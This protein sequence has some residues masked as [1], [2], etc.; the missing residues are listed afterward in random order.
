[1]SNRSLLALMSAALFLAAAPPP[2]LTW[3][4]Q[5]SGVTTRIRGLSAVSPRVAWASGGGG[6]ILRTVDGGATW[7]P[8]PIPGTAALDFRD[9]DAFSDRIASALSIGPGESSR[10]YRTTDGGEHWDLQF[11]STDP[12]VFL[13]A[14]AFWDA[15][16]GVAVSDSVNGAFVILTTDNGGRAWTRV[17]ADRLPP[18]LPGEGAFAASGTNVAVGAGNRAWIGTGASRVLRSADGGRS[19]NVA[20][21]PLPAGESSGIFSIAFRDTN[22]GVVVG[23]DYRNESAAADNAAFTSDGGTTWTLS[24]RRLGG[25]RSVVAWVP[26]TKSSFVAAGPSGLD[27]SSDDGRTWTPAGGAGL[28]TLSFARSTSTGWGAGDRGRLARLIVRD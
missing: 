3:Q 2:E 8:R 26:G 10:I 17:A 4:S 13:D 21:T 15:D 22:H 16:R 6:T 18:A 5:Q 25:Y 27:V 11:A 9:V 7:Q 23:G 28:D 12:A 24:S 14:M 20:A 19:W 1:M